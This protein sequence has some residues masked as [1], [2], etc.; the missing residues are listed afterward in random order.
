MFEPLMQGEEDITSWVKS[1]KVVDSITKLPGDASARKYYR[2]VCG[3]QTFIV[4]RMESFEQQGQSLPFLIMQQHLKQN[5]VKVPEIYDVDPKNG[6]ILLED[7]GDDTLL[8][9]LQDVSNAD[10]ERHLYE[11][12]LSD[13]IDL[14]LNSSPRNPANAGADLEAFRL[15]FDQEKL[16]WEMT[17]TIEHF[18][19]KH[20]KR[21]IRDAD[22]KIMLD[23]FSEICGFLAGLPTVLAHRDFHSR[24]IMVVSPAVG[25]PSVTANRLV[26]IDFQ[27][28]RLGP[29]TYDLAS[30]LKDSYYQLEE[31]QVSHLL[32]YYVARWEALTGERLSRAQFQYEFDMMSVQRNFKA[33]GS[34]A[35]FL[36]R[37]GDATYLKYIGNTFENIRRTLLKYP[38]YSRLREA[39]FHYYYF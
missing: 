12:V 25:H 6:L 26:M 1:S 31:D 5:G 21:Q 34:F 2:V 30:I 10:V 38:K 13:L 20:L 15:K 4:M 33:I 19:E 29:V 16:F 14:Q 17:N 18:Y 35:S 24:N 22:R 37:R 36:N 3:E 27:D 9:C 23:G 11:R 8:R 39:L 28:A 32:D 7:L